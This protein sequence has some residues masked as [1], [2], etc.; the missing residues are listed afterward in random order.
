MDKQKQQLQRDKF[1]LECVELSR[2]HKHLLIQA[3]T[4]TGKGLA[5]M[6]CIDASLSF[7]K[8]VVVV[9]EIIQIQ[10]FKEDLEKHGYSH[11]LGTKIQDI[12]CYASLKLWKSNSINL[13]LNEC[14][15]VSDL[16]EDV[17]KTIDFDQIISDSATV[18]AEIEEKLNSVYPL[19]KYSMSMDEAIEREILP[20]PS[21]YIQYIKL[22]STLKKHTVKYGQ[23]SV[24]LSDQEKS[25]WYD[26]NVR[27]WAERYEEQQELWQQKK[28]LRVAIERKQF[29][30]GC[31]TEYAKELLESFDNQRVVCFTGSTEQCEEL[32]GKYVVNSKRGKKANLSLIEQFNSG[33]IHRLVFHRMGKEGMNLSFLDIGIIA[34]LDSGADEGLSF[35]QTSGRMLRS[36]DPK[37]YILVCKNTN[38]EKYLRRAL[39]N[40]DD[41]YVIFNKL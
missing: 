27:Y 31:K 6:K 9:P 34:Q 36:D 28:L 38:D 35:L 4:G 1:Q 26:K 11:L 17:V 25:D 10:N 12:V 5:T 33:L 18:S 24:K 41:K 40:I 15:H 13:A 16:R 39:L 14:H 22:N 7:K 23:K 30:A 19:Y 21:V 8:W 32:G 29:L 3:P 20:I 37:I 2:K